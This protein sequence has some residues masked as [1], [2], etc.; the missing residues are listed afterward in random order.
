MRTYKQKIIQNM[1]AKSP[2]YLNG[3][4]SGIPIGLGYFVVAFTFGM[5]GSLMGMNPYDLIIMSMTNLTSAGQFAGTSLILSGATY[6]ELCT[7]V[8]IINIR[9]LLMSTAISQKLE[10][11]LPLYKRLILALDITDET[12][13]VSMIDVKEITFNYFMGLVTLPWFG[14]VAGTA[15]GALSNNI[16]SSELQS[17]ASIALYCMFI[18]L[19]MPPCKRK[20]DIRFVCLLTVAIRVIMSITPVIQEISSG[21]SIII[22]AVLASFLSALRFSESSEGVMA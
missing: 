21:Y 13:S 22:A 17:A 8:G 16:M 1:T 10:R 20:N 3:L 4:K 2:T 15:L 5:T 19:V 6:L 18:A 12:F 7:T 11:D 9:Y 14:W